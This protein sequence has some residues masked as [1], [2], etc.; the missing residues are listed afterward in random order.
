MSFR[1]AQRRGIPETLAQKR[2]TL[3]PLGIYQNLGDSSL[4]ALVQNDMV[5]S[6]DKLFTKTLTEESLSMKKLITG[7]WLV[8]HLSVLAV[9]IVLINLGWW[10]LRRLEE[11]RTRNETILAA[12]NQ[13]VLTVTRE[14]INPEAFHFHR[15]QVTGTFDNAESMLL[16]NRTLKNVPGMHLLTPLR[17]SDSDKVVLV[18]RGWLPKDH[19]RTA[20]DIFDEVTIE[21][22]A[23]RSQTRPSFLAPRDPPLQSGQTRLDSWFRVN[24]DRIQEQLPYPLLPIFI[25]QSPDPEAE[26]DS[27]PRRIEDLVLDEG[28]HLGYAIQW[29]SFAL[30]L[31]GIYVFFVR[32]ELKR[33]EL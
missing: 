25:E 8:R 29:F 10:Q 6:Y 24:I 5:G 20:Y 4:A 7:H 16:R 28:P 13:P 31:V 30:I 9:V 32:Q 26:P 1:G 17:I 19:N 18:D 14:D 33:Y 23:Y 21:G 11:K 22:I 12:L 27:L 15:V 2:S 3:C